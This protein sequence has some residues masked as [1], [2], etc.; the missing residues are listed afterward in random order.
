MQRQ[1]YAPGQ[2]EYTT[3]LGYVKRKCGKL[4]KLLNTVFSPVGK[5]RATIQTSYTSALIEII[6]Q[7]VFVWIVFCSPPEVDFQ[8]VYMHRR[9]SLTHMTCMGCSG[10]FS[11]TACCGALGSILCGICATTAF[12]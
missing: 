10:A 9:H 6:F 5:E 1:D 8:S 12:V 11:T 7:I 3:N 2:M 4:Y